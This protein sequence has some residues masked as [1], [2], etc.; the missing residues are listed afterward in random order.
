MDMNEVLLPGVGLRYDFTSRS[1][2]RIGV[3]AR[4]S[5]GF[6][7]VVYEDE[8]DPDEARPVFRLTGEEAEALAQI[9][10]APR[11]AERFADLTR[12]VPGLVAGQVAIGDASRFAGRLLGDSR[13]RTLTGASIVAVVRGEMV[14]ASPGPQERLLA[15]DVLVVIGT[16]EGLT[17]VE[18]VFAG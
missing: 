4:R 17:A 8:D 6:D 9:L 11:I 1:G 5:G 14:I 12:E 3:V 16:A 10:G 13:A 18:R 7:V 15:G 2:E